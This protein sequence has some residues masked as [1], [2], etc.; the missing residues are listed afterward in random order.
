[1][2]T[3]AARAAATPVAPALASAMRRLA[4]ARD[5]DV[6]ACD[7]D[8]QLPEPGELAAGL[9][10]RLDAVAARPGAGALAADLA[11]LR[12]ELEAVASLVDLAA[13]ELRAAAARNR[14]L[15]DAVALVLPADVLPR[16]PALELRALTQ[17]DLAAP[18][19]EGGGVVRRTAGAAAM[20]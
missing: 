4:R 12:A 20:P 1:M 2:S 13:D 11:A 18:N 3:P 19:L 16:E 7:L 14:D 17:A 5:A 15:L 6:A 8:L 9:T 10:G